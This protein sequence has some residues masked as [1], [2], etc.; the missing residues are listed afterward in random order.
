MKKID[1][2]ILAPLL[3]AAFFAI[4]GTLTIDDNFRY[5]CVIIFVILMFNI[6]SNLKHFELKN[7]I[8]TMKEQNKIYQDSLDK[9][10]FID[11]Q[12]FNNLAEMIN[13]K[14]NDKK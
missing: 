12:Q 2:T 10:K 4:S 11:D 1:F 3:I 6:Q 9:M 13:K 14:L 7:K 5:F 8:E